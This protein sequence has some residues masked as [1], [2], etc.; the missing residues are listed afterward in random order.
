[1][2]TDSLVACA[3]YSTSCKRTIRHFEQQRKPS[4]PD[5]TRARGAIRLCNDDVAKNKHR[6]LTCRCN[7][8]SFTDEGDEVVGLKGRNVCRECCCC[9]RGRS[10]CTRLGRQLAPG[11][12]I[13]HSERTNRRGA[14][15]AS[16][17]EIFS[18]DRCVEGAGNAPEIAIPR[19]GTVPV[20]VTER[21]G[22][23]P[24]PFPGRLRTY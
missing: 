1:M 24:N 4:G 9:S 19:N 7:L 10:G 13:E 14:R 12:L 17:K 5:S 15:H 18:R 11:A 23:H 20:S 8:K 6:F 22:I 16:Y 3:Y 21:S 2:P